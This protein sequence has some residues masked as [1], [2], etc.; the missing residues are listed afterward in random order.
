MR[1]DAPF[2]KPSIGIDDRRRSV[3]ELMPAAEKVVAAQGEQ[4]AAMFL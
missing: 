1:L 2:C 4:I 3:A